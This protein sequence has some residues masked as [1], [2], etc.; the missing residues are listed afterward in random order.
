MTVLERHRID[1]PDVARWLIVEA[2]WTLVE[3]QWR[4]N[5]GILQM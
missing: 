3:A 4:Q 5:G 1:V 2:L